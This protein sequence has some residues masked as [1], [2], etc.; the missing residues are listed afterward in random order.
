MICTSGSAFSPEKNR[1]AYPPDPA[2]PIAHPDFE[3]APRLAFPNASPCGYPCARHPSQ[4]FRSGASHELEPSHELTIATAADHAGLLP[5]RT[6]G[7]RL[8]LGTGSTEPLRLP[9]DNTAGGGSSL[10]R[11]CSDVSPLGLGR[12]HPLRTR[13]NSNPA[14]FRPAGVPFP[15]RGAQTAP[16]GLGGFRPDRWHHLTHLREGCRGR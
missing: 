2:D 16:E 10:S 11:T 14:G 8:P 13:S 7:L 1:R 6:H 9:R 3:T 15:G 5:R 12:E 4:R